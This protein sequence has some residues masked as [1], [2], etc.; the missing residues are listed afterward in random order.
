MKLAWILVCFLFV[1]CVTPTGTPHSPS[2]GNVDRLIAHPESE[3]AKKC[4]PSWT[5]EALMT[6]AGLEREIKLRD[7]K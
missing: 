4:A 2:A 7:S 5:R 1:G 3:Q 6:I